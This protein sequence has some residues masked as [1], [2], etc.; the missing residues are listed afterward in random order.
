MDLRKIA[1]ALVVFAAVLIT[2][3]YQR[4]AKTLFPCQEPIAYTIGAFDR[5]FG[6]SQKY[7]LDAL[8]EA[9]AIWEDSIDKE[10]FVYAPENGELLVNLIYDYRQEVTGTLSGLEDV[11]EEN[12]A[13]YKAL[14]NKYAGL[15][16]EYNNEKSIYDARASAFNE[17]EASYQQKVETWNSGKRTS[18]EQF[19]ELEREKRA[20]ETEVR[21]LK[22]LE[23]RLNEMVRVINTL[24]GTL[25]RLA[26]SLN[27]SVEKYNTIGASRG[28]TFTG[29]IYHSAEGVQEIDVYE[30]SSRDKLVRILAH[31][32]GHALG[33]EHNDDPKA[34]MYRLNEGDTKVLT[35]S[36]I[37]ALQTLCYTKDIKN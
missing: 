26:K 23:T 24:V 25:N 1:I 37:A 16:V 36:D 32:F 17:R 21:E 34:V 14:Q 5:K 10:L 35:A 30:F 28:E 2:W 8:S 6:I 33:L 11:L 12:E 18:R 31:E 19:D 9:E 4:S 29:G 3:N 20:L 22:V 7:F 27:L 13:T 15:K